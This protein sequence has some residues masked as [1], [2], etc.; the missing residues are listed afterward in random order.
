M[1][2]DE[3][4]RRVREL[5]P[6]LALAVVDGERR[7]DLVAHLASCPACRDE[8]EGLTGVADRVPL[9]A[10]AAEPPVGFESRVTARLRSA[11]RPRRWRVP[12]AVAALVAAAVAGAVV[13]RATSDPDTA[14][15]ALRAAPLRAADGEPAGEVFVHPGRPGWLF[16]RMDYPEVGG[17]HVV[18]LVVRDGTSAVLGRVEVVGG[19]ASVGG[20]S[21]VPVEELRTV[22]VVGPDGEVV[23]RALVRS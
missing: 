22:Q 18:R 1:T 16:V 8:V 21:P 10:P 5:G 6:E 13:E 19:R 7:A 11:R 17:P 23:C 20:I 4:C 2:D 9:L 12:V 15:A 14:T 3:A